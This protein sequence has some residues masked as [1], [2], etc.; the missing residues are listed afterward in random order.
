[1]KRTQEPCL[2]FLNPF[3]L[4]E[5]LHQILEASVVRGV[6][7]TYAALLCVSHAFYSATSSLIAAH[8]SK[9]RLL[10]RREL[11]WHYRSKKLDLSSHSAAA[12]LVDREMLRHLTRVQKL[13]LGDNARISSA[14]LQHLTQLCSLSLDYNQ[15]IGSFALAP[16]TNLT[17]LSLRHNERVTLGLLPSAVTVVRFPALTALSLCESKAVTNGEL[18]LYSSQLLDLRLAQDRHILSD[19]VAGLTALQ[20]L[21]LFGNRSILG[22]ALRPL[23]ASLTS[24]DI[25]KNHIIDDDCLARL[26]ALTSLSLTANECITDRALS[27]LTGLRVLLLDD[28]AR[29]SEHALWPL[30]ALQS[31]S[32]NA[33]RVI[34]ARVPRHLTSL[35]QLTLRHNRSDITVGALTHLEQLRLEYD[36]FRGDMEREAEAW[37]ASQHAGASQH[38]EFIELDRKACVL[39]WRR[40]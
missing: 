11:T 12:S 26:T 37:L 28:N 19:T 34:T 20:R 8:Y 7:H 22:Y 1:M 5:L 21:N 30:T 23:A 4:P 13:V 10:T 17:Q 2:A 16:L 31:L 40:L 9:A 18:A 38:Y 6:F 14:C 32:L 36:D 29:I 35:R 27:L 39:Q 24:L 3:T 15:I 25:G 33:N